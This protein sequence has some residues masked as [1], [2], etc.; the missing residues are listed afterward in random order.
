MFF[1]NKYFSMHYA[2]RVLE[3]ADITTD[4]RIEIARILST[5]GHLD[6]CAEDEESFL[7]GLCAVDGQDVGDF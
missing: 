5:N 2:I 6:D 3:H 7:E 4:I 1:L